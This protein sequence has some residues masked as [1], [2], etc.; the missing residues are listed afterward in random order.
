MVELKRSYP[1]SMENMPIPSFNC[2]TPSAYVPPIL[3]P[4]ESGPISHGGT[5]G[6]GHNILF[7]R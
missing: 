4:D 6:L 3:K 7:C 2:D 1:F 5:T